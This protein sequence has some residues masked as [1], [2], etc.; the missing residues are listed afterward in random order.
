MEDGLLALMEIEDAQANL[1]YEGESSVLELLKGCFWTCG[2][3]MRGSPHRAQRG[4]TS[5]TALAHAPI[6]DDMWMA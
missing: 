4:L 6:A 2:T 1:P 5:V 3:P